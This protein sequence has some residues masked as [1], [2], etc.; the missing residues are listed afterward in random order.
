MHYHSPWVLKHLSPVSK[1]KV[2]EQQKLDE[3][4]SCDDDVQ[5]DEFEGKNKA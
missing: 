5:Q 3:M 2:E 1:S 4:R